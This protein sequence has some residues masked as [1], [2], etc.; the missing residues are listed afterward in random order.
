MKPP[1]WLWIVAACAAH[2][3][4]WTAWFILAARHPVMDVPLRSAP[5]SRTPPG[6]P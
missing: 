3:T 2:L 6:P 4:I 1:V 5:I